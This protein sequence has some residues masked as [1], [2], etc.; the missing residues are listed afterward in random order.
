MDETGELVSVDGPDW[1]VRGGTVDE[2]LRVVWGELEAV[3][4]VGHDGMD[5]EGR[6]RMM[7]GRGRRGDAS[8]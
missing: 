5:W 3:D 4:W 1:G 8:V 2:D 7:G 6:E